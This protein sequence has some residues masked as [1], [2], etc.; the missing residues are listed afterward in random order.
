MHPQKIQWT[1]HA[2]NRAGERF[3]FRS[4]IVIPNRVI[5]KQAAD[6]PDG[7]EF[8]VKRGR[9]VYVC[10]LD[11]DTVWII[12]V[13]FADRCEQTE[14]EHSL[15]QRLKAANDRLRE[16]EKCNGREQQD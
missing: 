11:G 7:T 10:K 1:K 6:L 2:V 15:L 13:L 9:V 8:R 14:F 3:G 4:D 5:L 12:T 16:L